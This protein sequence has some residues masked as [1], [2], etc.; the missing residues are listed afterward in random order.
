MSYR[1]PGKR[2]RGRFA[3]AL[4][5]DVARRWLDTAHALFDAPDLEA[6]AAPRGRHET[7]AETTLSRTASR[8]CVRS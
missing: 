3:E 6:P 1:L 2:Y 4:D 7:I 8:R 5:H